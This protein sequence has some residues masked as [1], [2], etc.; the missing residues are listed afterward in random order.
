MMGIPLA[1]TLARG[2][3]VVDDIDLGRRS[4]GVLIGA[5]LVILGNVMPKNLPPLSSLR[6]DAT[7]QQAFQRLV[8]WTWVLCGLASAIT[9]LALTIDSAEMTTTMLVVTSMV[10]TIVQLLRL[11]KPRKNQPASGLNTHA[12]LP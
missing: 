3:S 7:R 5:F 1:L 11:R 10:V 4:T 6:C 8:G 12:T 2:Y 9:W